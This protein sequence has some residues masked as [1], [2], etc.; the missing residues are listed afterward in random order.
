MGYLKDVFEPTTVPLSAYLDYHNQERNVQYHGVCSDNYDKEFE[1]CPQHY[2]GHSHLYDELQDFLLHHIKN[3]CVVKV[4][5]QYASKLSLKTLHE[6]QPYTFYLYSMLS[7]HNDSQI[8]HGLIYP[9]LSYDAKQHLLC[10]RTFQRFFP[11]LTSVY[12]IIHGVV[13]YL[14]SILSFLP[15]INGCN[16]RI[17]F[18]EGS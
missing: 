18:V 14:I 2:C 17:T 7:V 11:L 16:R 4:L 13:Q 9:L 15:S 10:I 5:L 8:N 6:F 3:T 1:Y 12:D